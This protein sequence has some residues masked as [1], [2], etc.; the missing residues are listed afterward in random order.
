MIIDKAQ[1]KIESRKDRGER[2][3][4]I[5][6][7]RAVSRLAGRADGDREAIVRAGSFDERSARKRIGMRT[8][9]RAP[10]GTVHGDGL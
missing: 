2:G 9:R 7:C 8:S 3:N 4:D 1:A 10:I 6:L 5:R